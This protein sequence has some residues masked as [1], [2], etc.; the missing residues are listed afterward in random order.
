[1]NIGSEAPN[2]EQQSFFEAV[3]GYEKWAELVDIFYQGV[4]QDPVLSPMYPEHDMAGA[5]ERLTMFLVQYWGGPTTYSDT[6]GHPRLR[7]RHNP[8][9]INPDARD[10]WIGHMRHAV[11]TLDLPPIQAVTL[12]DYLERSAHSLLNSFEEDSPS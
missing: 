5:R 8:Y 2:G 4:E 12:M 1:M 10:R 6:R 7:M 9:R 11:A 3:G